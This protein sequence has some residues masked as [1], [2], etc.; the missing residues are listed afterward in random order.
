MTI[1]LLLAPAGG[2]KTAYAIARI[3]ALRA[4]APLAPVCVVLPNFPQVAA[5]RRRLAHAGGALGVEIGTFYRLYADILARAGVP[6]PRLFDPVQHR[7]LRAIVDR[8]C[9]EGRLRHYAPLRDKPGFI[10]ALRGL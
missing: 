3:R 6:A 4:A 5:F 7:L 1:E 8:L 2:G 10:R 9:D